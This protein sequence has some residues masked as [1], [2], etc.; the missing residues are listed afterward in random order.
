M[1]SIL[2]PLQLKRQYSAPLDESLVFLS[3]A[4][5]VAY[6]L[7][8]ATRYDGQ[9]VSDLQDGKVYVLS[10][11]NWTNVTGTIQS[12]VTYK[13][14]W[15]ADTN[16]PFLN[17]S[18]GT[19]GDVYIVGISGSTNF[20][21][22]SISFKI[23]D[24][25][26][27]SDTNEWEKVEL[28]YVGVTSVNSQTGIVSLTTDNITEGTNQY[29]TQSRARQSLTGNNGITYSNVTGVISIDSGY[30]GQN[31]ITT[32]G[33]VGTGT[34]NADVIGVTYGGTGASTKELGL[35]NLLPTQSGNS[36]KVLGTDGVTAVTWVDV[37]KS[38][39]PGTGISID[40]STPQSPTISFTGNTPTQ[41]LT[42]ITVGTNLAIN[43]TNPL[44]PSITFTG[45]TSTQGLTGITV[46]SG[47]GVAYTNPLSPTIS[48]TGTASNLGVG[49]VGV[50]AQKNG[51]T[52]EFKSLSAG[53]NIVITTGATTIT[54]SST[55]SG[56]V[57]NILP[58]TTLTYASANAVTWN[59][60]GTS[61]NAQLTL[62]ASTT[63]LNFTNLRNG[64]YGTL[65]LTQGT[66]GNKTITLGTGGT[67]RV[68][69]DGGGVI[70]LSSAASSIDIISFV[71]NGTTLFWTYGVR[72]T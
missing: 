57:S 24:I 44:N 39:K 61:S 56:N 27:Y 6:G 12:P 59:V 38:I 58:F 8:G 66:G 2:Y 63:T 23:G 70:Y 45:N 10:G 68:V 22:G 35:N 50:F 60:S 15:D 28:G 64:E 7:T 48:Y 52:L 17:N 26:V 51:S 36:G 16:T 4:S 1:A 72:Y 55:A 65:I 30:V 42:G 69:L 67:H 41:G 14:S 25:V 40:N 54:I 18:A 49:G 53:T 31:T 62:T 13:A 32:L 20:G 37:V 11:T 71:Y 29:F 33:T 46:G 19:V 21:A 3:T 9:I 5:R 34:W 43:N 47:I